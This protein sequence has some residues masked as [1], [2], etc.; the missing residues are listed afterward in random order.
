MVRGPTLLGTANR[1]SWPLERDLLAAANHSDLIGLAQAQ[2]LGTRPV[3]RGDGRRDQRR[4]RGYRRRR[5]ARRGDPVAGAD[6]ADR[7]VR[8]ADLGLEPDPEDDVRTG[9]LIVVDVELVQ[10]VVVEREVVRPVARLQ[11]RIDGQD[12]GDRIGGVRADE[13]VPVGDVRGAVDRGD[14]RLAM[15]GGERIGQR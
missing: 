3:E 7:H 10:Q 2:A 15:A 4:S 1:G 8:H 9:V 11:E 6:E 12:H 13:G 5:V 14:R